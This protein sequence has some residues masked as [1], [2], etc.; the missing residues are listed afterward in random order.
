MRWLRWRVWNDSRS[1]TWVGL[2]A[3]Y[4]S[5]DPAVSVDDYAEVLVDTAHRFLGADIKLMVE[6]G[7]SMV[8]TSGVSLYTVVTVKRGVRTHVAIDGGMGDNLEV[9]L[10]GQ[11]FQPWVLNQSGRSGAMEPSDLVGHHCESGD[12]LARDA[13]MPTAEVGDLVVVPA[14]GA[15]TFTMSNNYNG[16]LRPPVVLCRDGSSRLSVRRETLRDLL[17]REM[18]PPHAAT[19]A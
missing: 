3:R 15:Y 8:C 7:R 4:V 11:R 10:Y 18:L 14:T 1:M 9:S 12:I 16:A 5:S 2:A 17:A 6:P 19:P 13:L